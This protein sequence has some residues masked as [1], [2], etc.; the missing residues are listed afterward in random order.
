M[1]GLVLQNGQGLI[2]GRKKEML[3]TFFLTK[4]H[5]TKLTALNFKNVNQK[6]YEIFKRLLTQ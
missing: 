3:V 2:N 5:Y 4:S 6:V 1:K